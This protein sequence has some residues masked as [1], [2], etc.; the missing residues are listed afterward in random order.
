MH[1]QFFSSRDFSIIQPQGIYSY[2]RNKKVITTNIVPLH[3]ENGKETNTESEI[4]EVLDDY[5]ASVFTVEDTY[6]IQEIT[7]AQSNLIPLSDCDITEDTVTKTLDNIKINKTPDLDCIA[8]KVLKDAK[9]QIS[10]H[11]AILFNK[12][13]SSGRVPDTRK[14]ANVTHIQKKGR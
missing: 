5:F 6:E 12:S 11:L 9:Y 14:L 1:S 13:L 3:L 2:V 8:P 10:K 7:P 4:A